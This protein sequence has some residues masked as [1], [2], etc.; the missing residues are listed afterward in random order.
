MTR[1]APTCK[2]KGGADNAARM[3]DCYE[4]SFLV[5]WVHEEIPFIDIGFN[6]SGNDAEDLVDRLDQGVE[7][8]YAYFLVREHMST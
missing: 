5:R 2:N 1:A 7:K 6:N 8:F 3:D 4:P